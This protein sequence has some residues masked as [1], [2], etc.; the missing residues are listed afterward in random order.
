MKKPLTL[1]KLG[2]SIITDK[3][4]PDT[5]KPEILADLIGQIA[6]A[7]LKNPTEQFLLAHGQ[8]SFAHFPAHKYETKRGLINDQSLY[9]MALVLDS[10]GSLNR[11]V[12]HECVT[13][14]LPAVSW[15]SA[16]GVITQA[17]GQPSQ[18]WLKVLE[19][20][21]KLGLLPITSGD[22]VMDQTQGWAIW[23]GETILS[24]LARELL[25]LDYQIS[26]II[27]VGEV[28][29]V[30]DKTGRVIPQL[31]AKNWAE[32]QSAITTETKGID[33]TGGMLLK[34]EESLALV[35]ET[36]IETWILAGLEPN[37]L[38]KS[39]VGDRWLGTKITK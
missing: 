30:L 8:G 18:S 5:L 35:K 39:L 26:K 15:M 31:S 2:G 33:V 10:V 21:L 22:V 24:F 23:S 14:G 13:Q 25:K 12:I 9:G 17:G 27:Q 7:R 34:V 32:H 16:Q 20:Q 3:S 28:A 19:T 36:G 4:R 1:I 11:L 6:A 37:N 38:F 29:G